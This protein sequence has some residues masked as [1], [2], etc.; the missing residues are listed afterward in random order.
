[1]EKYK[2]ELVENNVDLEEAMY[3]FMD[4]EKL[5]FKFLAKFVEDNNFINLK[6]SLFQGMTKEAFFYAH[7][8]KGVTSNL[9][10][11][12]L[13][14]QLDIVVEY[15][16]ENELEKAKEEFALFEDSYITICMIIKN[17]I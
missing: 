9:A 13:F 17:H 11:K 6:N 1:M 12:G 2:S 5:Y 3:R 4:N 14:N 16:R 7:T 10:L 15:L 8:L